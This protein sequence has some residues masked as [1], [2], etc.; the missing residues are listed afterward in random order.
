MSLHIVQTDR[1]HN[2][3]DLSNISQDLMLRKQYPQWKALCQ[4]IVSADK[5]HFLRICLMRE[6]TEII[7][8]YCLAHYEGHMALVPPISCSHNSSAQNSLSGKGIAKAFEKATLTKL[9]MPQTYHQ[10]DQLWVC[11]LSQY[12]WYCS[13]LFGHSPVVVQ[14]IV[15]NLHC[16]Q[17]D[18][19]LPRAPLSY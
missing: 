7:F 11:L 2:K 12:R 9:L 15:L 18:S 8:P 5:Q 19:G 17:I 3:T 14:G 16:F 13:S 10:Q 1:I 6:K 4:T